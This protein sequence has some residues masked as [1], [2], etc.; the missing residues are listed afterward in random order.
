MRFST[1]PSKIRPAHLERQA[2]I[3]IRQLTLF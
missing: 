3:Y 2:F 1:T